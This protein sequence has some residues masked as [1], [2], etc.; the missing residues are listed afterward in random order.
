LAALASP[1]ASSIAAI[2]T[3]LLTV[4]LGAATLNVSG[5]TARASAGALARVF[6]RVLRHSVFRR[7]VIRSVFTCFLPVAG[8]CLSLAALEQ[9]ANLLRGHV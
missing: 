2:H 7:G 4:R 1:G 3:S 6:T 8:A 9:F 5:L